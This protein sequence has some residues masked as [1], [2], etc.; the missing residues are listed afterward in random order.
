[1]L[2]KRVEISSIGIVL[3]G[4]KCAEMEDRVQVKIGGQC[5]RKGYQDEERMTE[6]RNKGHV[7][8][9]I[10]AKIQI[11]IGCCVEGMATWRDWGTERN[12]QKNVP[13]FKGIGR[14]ALLGAARDDLEP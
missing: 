7:K 13:V 2:S 4:R 3:R 10:C 11:T 8:G 12:P 5:N 14:R 1:M 9:R 6:H